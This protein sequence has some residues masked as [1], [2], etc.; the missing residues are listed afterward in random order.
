M[1]TKNI[2]FHF[3]I[4]TSCS[5]G[6]LQAVGQTDIPTFV[7]KTVVV[8]GNGVPVKKWIIQQKQ[9]KYIAILGNGTILEIDSEGTWLCTKSIIKKRNLPNE[10]KNAIDRYLS[11]G[12]QIT[13]IIE[14]KEVGNSG[15]SYHIWYN[16]KKKNGRIFLNSAGEILQG[17]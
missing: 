17:D 8:N 15:V 2:Y 4:V 7:R 16:S 11:E 6:T 10:M 13:R 3:L 14:T 5:L 9:G 12:Y 1:K